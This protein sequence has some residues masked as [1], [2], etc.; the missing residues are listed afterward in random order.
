MKKLLNVLYIMTPDSYLHCQNETIAIEVGGVEKHRVPAHHVE[1]IVFFG[2][3]S[4]STPLIE[5]CGKRGITLSFHAESGKFYGRVCG[6]VNGNVLLRRAQYR[7]L[8]SVEKSRAIVQS[9]LYGKLTNSRNFLIHVIRSSKEKIAVQKVT[10]VI[11][12]LDDAVDKLADMPDIDSMRG[13]EGAAAS[14]YFSVFDFLFQSDSEKM[15]FD[16]RSKYPPENNVNALLSFVYVLLKND[17]QSALESVGLDVAAGFLHTL[18][19]GRPSL[20]LDI[21]EE[22][23]APLAD[24]LVVTLLNTRK[25]KESDFSNEGGEIKLSDD[26]RRIVIDCWQKRKKEE[27]LHPFFHEKMSVGLIAY[28]QAQLLA[29][30]LRGDADGY[31]PMVWR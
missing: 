25:I 30:Y 31:P 29:R 26:A 1:S 7:A 15:H 9:V 27:I 17:V 19:A 10:E 23:R 12:H 16:T 6:P 4:V 11:N 24:K 21:M 8:D 5:F 20:A 2:K 13:I 14:Q 22:F 3:G 18:R 28:A